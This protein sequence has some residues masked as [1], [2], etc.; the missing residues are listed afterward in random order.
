LIPK[1]IIPTAEQLSPPI[2][3]EVY[4]YGGHVG[5]ISGGR[6]GK[7]EYWLEKRIGEYLQN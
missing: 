2:Q 5:F 6:P 3:L 7:W 4:P 1:A